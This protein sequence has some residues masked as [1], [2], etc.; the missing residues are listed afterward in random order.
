M[1]YFLAVEIW[2]LGTL[3]KHCVSGRIYD[4]P[5]PFVSV[6]LML[7]FLRAQVSFLS[8]YWDLEH[9]KKDSSTCLARG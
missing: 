7:W 1:C 2:I 4:L 8:G 6:S 3:N 5:R 9:F